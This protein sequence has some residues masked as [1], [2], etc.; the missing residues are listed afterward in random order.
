MSDECKVQD[1]LA[2]Y[3]RATDRPRDARSQGTLFTDDAT[4]QIF[5][6]TGPDGYEPVGVPIVG[7]PGVR[8]AVDNGR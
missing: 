7:G 6:K 1:V 2:R 4:A 5:A 3:V 8:Y